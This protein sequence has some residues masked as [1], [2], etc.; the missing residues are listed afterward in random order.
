MRN[1]VCGPG[2]EPSVEFGAACVEWTAE[3][4]YLRARIEIAPDGVEQ[5]VVEE[6]LRR[7]A[8]IDAGL[9]ETIPADQV[10]AEARSRLK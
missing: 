1:G 10:I 4:P 5:S 7:S 2:R 8:E 3:D 6:A 9:V